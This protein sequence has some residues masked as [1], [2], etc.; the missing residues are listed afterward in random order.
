MFDDGGGYT[1]VP[2]ALLWFLVMFVILFMIAIF[3]IWMFPCK[4]CEENR[5]KRLLAAV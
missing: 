1:A 3:L 2:R 5:R 4:Q